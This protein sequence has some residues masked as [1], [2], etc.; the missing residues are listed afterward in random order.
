MHV[1]LGILFGTIGFVLFV[2]GSITIAV[3]LFIVIL[4]CLKYAKQ[5]CVA[6]AHWLQTP[7]TS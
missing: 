4:T 5:A 7:F 3:K 2:F 6:F 1:T